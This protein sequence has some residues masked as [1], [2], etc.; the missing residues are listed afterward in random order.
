VIVLCGAEVSGMG[1]SGMAKSSGASVMEASSWQKAASEM[2][3]E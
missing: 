2:A 1:G 3:L